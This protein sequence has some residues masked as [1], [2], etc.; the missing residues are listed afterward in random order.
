MALRAFDDTS[1]R[2]AGQGAVAIHCWG[3]GAY[4][5]TRDGHKALLAVRK[6]RPPPPPPSSS[7]AAAAALAEEQ[8]RAM[9]ELEELT[10]RRG[11]GGAGD[12]IGAGAGVGRPSA[13]DLLGHAAW[14]DALREASL[15]PR[16]RRRRRRQQ[17]RQTVR[18]SARVCGSSAAPTELRTRS[19]SRTTDLHHDM[20]TR[21]RKTPSWPRSW[22]SFSLLSLCSH[23]NAW[24]NLHLL[25]Q[26]DAFLA[27]GPPPAGT[28]PSVGAFPSGCRHRAPRGCEAC[29]R[30]PFSI[31]TGILPRVP[32]DKCGLGWQPNYA[33]VG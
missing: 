28:T 33:L 18:C 26:P 13:E 17:P 21:V 14:T 12:G 25:R 3:R 31:S 10:G 20:H 30:A 24:A 8:H 4:I 32:R 22:A 29:S 11:G 19:R 27:R 9:V 5:E 15:H 23:R 16:R 7:L 6:H 1:Q 2:D